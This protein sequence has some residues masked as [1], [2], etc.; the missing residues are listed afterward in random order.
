[1]ND[2]G[3]INT[4]RLIV[5][6]RDEIEHFRQTDGIETEQYIQINKAEERNQEEEAEKKTQGVSI[7]DKEEKRSF[8]D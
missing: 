1:M 8:T 4:P 7:G 3:Q 6:G 2:V 5:H